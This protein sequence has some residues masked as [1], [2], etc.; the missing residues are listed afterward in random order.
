MFRKHKSKKKQDFIY[1]PD[2]YSLFIIFN[3]RNWR[4]LFAAAI[5]VYYYIGYACLLYYH[6]DFFAD[7]KKETEGEESRVRPKDL[8][9][10]ELGRSGYILDWDKH[11]GPEDARIFPKRLGRISG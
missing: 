6:G 11:K 10:N 2:V 4:F 3:C 8:E 7:F 1:N 5:S 9:I